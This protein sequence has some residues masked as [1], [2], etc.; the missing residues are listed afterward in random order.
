[1]D[2]K[3]R[4]F[5]QISATA[6][7]SIAALNG[8]ALALKTMQ[9]TK[10][11]NPLSS[12]PDVGWEKLYHDQYRYDRSFTYACSPNDT[13]QCRVRAF[14]RNGVVMRVEQN[15]AHHRTFKTKIVRQ[16]KKLYGSKN[17]WR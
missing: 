8:K 9:V 6:A 4:K 11:D 12:Y 5:L 1:M 2:V 15:Y 16:P 17:I 7:A 14:V 10:V 3:R 13:H